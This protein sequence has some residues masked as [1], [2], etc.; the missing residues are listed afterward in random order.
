MAATQAFPFSSSSF[1]GHQALRQGTKPLRD[2]GV[3]VEVVKDGNRHCPVSSGEAVLEATG[4][5]RP[6]VREP[7]LP[8]PKIREWR[9]DRVAKGTS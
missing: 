1:E 5:K 4:N 2:A 3:L 9:T 7:H 6:G 8:D